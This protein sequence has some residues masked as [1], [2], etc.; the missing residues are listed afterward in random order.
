[1]DRRLRYGLAF[2]ALA[3][4]VLL[5]F[6]APVLAQDTETAGDKLGKTIT[7]LAGPIV[8][9]IGGFTALAAFFKRDVGLAFSTL[10]ITLVVG[11]FIVAPDSI[12]RF[13]ET[14]WESV[15]TGA[16]ATETEPICPE[17]QELIAGGSECG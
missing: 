12:E 7:D 4:G 17:G 13:S 6:A 5:T 15:F 16:D 11:G 8:F 1:M 2:G 10:V 14:L 3:L 9:S